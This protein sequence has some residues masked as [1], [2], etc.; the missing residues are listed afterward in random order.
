MFKFNFYSPGNPLLKMEQNTATF[1]SFWIHIS[2]LYILYISK[3][4]PKVRIYSF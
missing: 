3:K 1:I 4:L 2:G